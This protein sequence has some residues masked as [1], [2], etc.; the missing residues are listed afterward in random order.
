VNY[1]F[2]KMGF[3]TS[4]F[5]FTSIDVVLVILYLLFMTVFFRILA[6]MFRKTKIIRFIEITMVTGI[7]Q[8]ILNS[9][10]LILWMTAFL[11][12]NEWNVMT[13]AEVFGSVASYM[14]LALIVF[15]L[16]MMIVFTALYW[17]DLRKVENPEG[18]DTGKKMQVN[19]LGRKYLFMPFKD[20]NLMH[21]S[22]PVIFL[23]RRILVAALFGFVKNDGFLQLLGL[24]LLSGMMLVYH[25]SYQPFVS[26]FRNIIL[27]V[28]EL[29]YLLICLTIF[30]YVYPNIK[31][32][33]FLSQ[34]DIVVGLFLPLFWL[35]LFIPV[36]ILLCKICGKRP[37]NHPIFQK[38]LP[39]DNTEGEDLRDAW[40]TGQQKE[41]EEEEE[42]A[43]EKVEEPG[44]VPE[45]P[46]KAKDEETSE[47][48]ESEESE[49]QTETIT[50]TESSSS[51]EN[52]G[53]ADAFAAQR[54]IP[55]AD[56][57]L[58]TQAGFSTGMTGTLEAE[59]QKY[60]MQEKKL[61]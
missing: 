33:L 20:R 58:D 19:S 61:N 51:G 47:S 15:A 41:L 16:I 31:P 12:I 46:E 55:S 1:N 9:T 45:N 36:G 57:N 14:Y 3:T 6:Q 11:N 60:R 42:K 27:T 56:V 26:S 34:A 39:V 8:F 48:V 37:K 43:A 54:R 28:L 50:I 52:E 53:D 59:I 29:A 10:C 38:D 32:D 13:E 24:S 49:L 7:L 30:P 5:I 22:Y 21:Y 44:A 23:A 40:I 35:A 17:A 18:G 4:S 25:T 2:K